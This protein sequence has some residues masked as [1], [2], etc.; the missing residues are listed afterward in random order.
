MKNLF[1]IQIAAL[2][3]SMSFSSCSQNIDPIKEY[4]AC[5]GAEPFEFNV[6]LPDGKK[7]YIFVPN[8]FTPN[9]DGINDIFAPVLSSEVANMDYLVIQ[10]EETDGATVLLYQAEY[11]TK[12]NLHLLGWNGK[13]KNG[14][15]YKGAFN[16]TAFC[17]LSDGGAFAVKGTACAI[18][19]DDDAKYFKEK[20]G[21]F[22]PVQAR[23][24]GT[25]DMTRGNGEDDCFD[26]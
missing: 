20:K 13:D 9:G 11:I 25:L 2:F 24:D 4:E 14:K 10:K 15:T 5:C 1:K 12:D 6:E 23:V 21:C 19:C 7:A 18:A 16:Y 17:N 3:F 26:R 22:Y 8:A